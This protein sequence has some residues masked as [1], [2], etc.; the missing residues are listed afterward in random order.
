M[1]GVDEFQAT[2]AE[3]LATNRQHAPRDYG[4]I[5][6]PCSTGQWMPA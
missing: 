1:I 5:C 3:W 6:P 4:A 2:A